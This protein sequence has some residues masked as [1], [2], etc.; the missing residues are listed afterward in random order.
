[1]SEHRY[2]DTAT[3]M[4]VY[5]ATDREQRLLTAIEEAIASLE[6]GMVLGALDTL[7]EVLEKEKT[8]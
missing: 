2:W 4:W 6:V 8:K 5:P 7:R 3:Q 1:M